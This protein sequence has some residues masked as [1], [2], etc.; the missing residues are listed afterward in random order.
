MVHSHF[1]EVLETE[2][3]SIGNEKQYPGNVF[4]KAAQ[5]QADCVIEYMGVHNMID[6]SDAN[7]DFTTVAGSKMPM[8]KDFK[9]RKA[10]KWNLPTVSDCM[11]ASSLYSALEDD[12][13]RA[14]KLNIGMIKTTKYPLLELIDPM[15]MRALVVVGMGCDT[16][17][18]G[19]PGI[20][21]ATI[22]KWKQN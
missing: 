18:T 14:L 13:M 1:V 9:M 7:G 22:V 17:P 10:T 8:I 11:L 4:F 16:F 12:V 15:M 21:T 3:N 19:A 6:N 2:V 20:G 5:M